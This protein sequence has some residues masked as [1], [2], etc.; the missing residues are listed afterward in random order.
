MSADVLMETLVRDVLPY[1]I[2]MS[3]EMPKVTLET[4]TD[5]A[6]DVLLRKLGSELAEHTASCKSI[7]HVHRMCNAVIP[8]LKATLH[9]LFKREEE[10]EKPREYLQL[11]LELKIPR[12]LVKFMALALRAGYPLVSLPESAKATSEIAAHAWTLSA[13]L[14]SCLTGLCPKD[15]SSPGLCPE[16]T[17]SPQF[18]QS[19]A[20]VEQLAIG[21]EGQEPGKVSVCISSQRSH[22]NPP[23][24]QLC[25][26]LLGISLGRN[27]SF[28]GSVLSPVLYAALQQLSF[29]F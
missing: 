12:N 6:A 20:L 22:H 11:F 10:L 7:K 9:G 26:K 17:S 3:H 21:A 14:F 23:V 8:P 1:F 28:W 29:R 5:K 19:I 16:D 15:P 18:M 27:A 24:L 13:D 25:Q 2:H 4:M